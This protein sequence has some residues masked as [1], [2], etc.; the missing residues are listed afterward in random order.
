MKLRALAALAVTFAAATAQGQNL[1]TNGSFESPFVGGSFTTFGP[2]NGIAAW[3][4]LGGS[5]DLVA[6]YWDAKDGLQ[7]L[8]LNGNAR[9]AIAQMINTNV[10]NLYTVSFWIAG[11]PDA[12]WNKEMS[13]Y[14]NNVRLGNAPVT[15]VLSHGWCQDRRTWRH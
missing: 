1:A 5:V 9:G 15:V 11:N 7:S 12:P 2:G 6:N 14:W 10:G 8:D 4:I 13:V 3:T